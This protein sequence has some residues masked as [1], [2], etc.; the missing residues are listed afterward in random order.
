M[1]A[2]V[3]VQPTDQ[4]T[5]E[6]E[7]E[8]QQARPHGPGIYVLLA[9]HAPSE[10]SVCV[11]LEGVNTLSLARGSSTRVE[12]ESGRDYRLVIADSWM[13]GTHARITRKGGGFIVEDAGS[14][15]GTLDAEGET[16]AGPR[17]LTDGMVF[18]VGRTLLLYRSQVAHR[19][20]MVR[21]RSLTPPDAGLTTFCPDFAQ[22]TEAMQAVATS[23]LPLLILGETGTGKEV[24]ARAMHRMS[25]RKGRFVAVNCGGIPEGLLESELFGVIKGAFSGAHV[26]REGLVLAAHEGT[27]FLDEIGELPAAAQASLLRVLQERSVVAVGGTEAR[28]VDFRLVAATHRDLAAA[29]A[30]GD[31][32]E[33]LLARL[34]GLQVRLP[35]LRDRIEDLG[36]L[37]SILLEAQGASDATLTLRASLRLA[38]HPWPHNI[39]ELGRTLEV[40]LAL[41]G[42]GAIKIEHLPPSLRQDAAGPQR[43]QATLTPEDLAIKQRLVASLESHEGNVSAVARDLGK[44]RMQVHRWMKRFEL[45]PES[46]R[47]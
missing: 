31:F 22:A 39:R 40:G 45:I 17:P 6:Y 38:A 14:K 21:S 23:T 18:A 10:G 35:P 19:A 44:A 47:K 28:D 26:D 16:M 3:R 34:G 13:S 4:Q 42:K 11:P 25:G 37:I 32:R 29:T 20:N 1:I 33:D 43:P 2:R 7:D 5:L 30:K 8:E 27:L 41:A 12:R 9:A 46:F 15:N 36:L 24:A